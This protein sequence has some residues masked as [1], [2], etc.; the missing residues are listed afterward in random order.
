MYCETCGQL[1]CQYC[2]VADHV[3]HECGSVED[4]F[5]RHKVQLESELTTVKQ[6]LSILDAAQKDVKE[7]L[8]H[9]GIQGSVVEEQIQVV[10]QQTIKSIKESEQRMIELVRKEVKRKSDV[11][12]KQVE[13]MSS[14]H[15]QLEEFQKF[16]EEADIFT[17]SPQQLLTEECQ[18]LDD[19]KSIMSKVTYSNLQPMEE[20]DIKFTVD[21]DLQKYCS[22]LG[23]VYT[24]E[25]KIVGS[26]IVTA[27]ETAC[28]ELTTSSTIPIPA[29]L[30]SCQLIAPETSE[31]LESTITATESGG[32]N[33]SFTPTVRGPHQMSV[34]IGGSDI[35][36]GLFTVHAYPTVEMRDKA[37]I[38][39]AGITRPTG[40]AVSKSGEVMVSEWSTNC[41]QVLGRDGKKTRSIPPEGSGKKYF[42]H[43]RG[44]A[45]THD[46]HIL[47]VDSHRVQM[48]TLDGNFV[49]SVGQ[50][51]NAPLQFY[52]PFGIAV[53]PI[54]HQVY[55]ADS[56]NH[57]IQILN[58]DLTY[59]HMFGSRGRKD[60][61]FIYPVGVA[62]DSHSNVFVADY[63]NSRIQVFTTSGQFVFSFSWKM[64]FLS[65]W[66]PMGIA[67]D[68]MNGTVYVSANS[69]TKVSLFN[70][71][72][73]YIK[74]LQKVC[75][76]V[77]G[78]ELSLLNPGQLALD[79]T[80]NLYVCLYHNNTVVMY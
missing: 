70:S 33:I 76:P 22:K 13:E 37:I 75:Y 17:S 5:L 16:V 34:T 61:Q 32:C 51:G 80:G 56:G 78:L 31:L 24:H 29:N 28:F 54:S 41:I 9:I 72:G 7:R 52:S 30:V 20:A 49:E 8:N 10:S 69:G 4:M 65:D 63:H 45:I 19:M 50:K 67:I 40:V 66:E 79:D 2:S 57:R 39:F 11:L 47:V 18:K 15:K 62:F 73:Q 3:G 27:G 43:P 74:C 38:G 46:N 26:K 64:P 48:F 12:S 36:N 68:H 6:Q 53:H 58:Q 44:I 60:G 42:Q 35:P 25:V 77:L 21:K 55:V 23:D 59:S 14:S 1:F 71:Q